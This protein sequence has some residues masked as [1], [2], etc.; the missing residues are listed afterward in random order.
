MCMKKLLAII[1]LITAC[2]NEEDPSAEILS[3][4]ELIGKWK[5]VEHS[6]SIGDATQHWNEVIDGFIYN[7]KSNGTFTSTDARNCVGGTYTIQDN[8]LILN[9]NKTEYIYI[10]SIEE[11]HLLLFPISPVFC[12]EGCS[13]KFRELP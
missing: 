8:H 11:E 1:L 6:F 9:C 3:S 13:Y 2:V 4:H 7:F 5:L 12:I 10:W